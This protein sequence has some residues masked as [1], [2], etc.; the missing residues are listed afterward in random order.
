MLA[1]TLFTV[2]AC[3]H[4][5]RL[6]RTGG[7]W[8]LVEFPALVA[9]LVHP[10]HGPILYDTGYADHFDLATVPFPERLYR[11][12]TPYHLPSDQTLGAQLGRLGLTPADIRLCVIS[13]F[14]GDHVAGLRDLPN[15]TF[16]CLRDD[17]RALAQGS[18]LS[19]LRRGFLP[20]L[21]PSDFE[22]RMQ[23]AD[24][25][26]S[27]T[28]PG[29]LSGLGPAVDLLGDGS[30]A[31]VRLPGHTAGQLGLVFRDAHD[32]RLLLC[33]DAAWHREAIRS[34]DR[35]ARAAA[36]IM[37]DWTAYLATLGR[38]RTVAAAAPDLHIVP[39]HCA[40]SIAAYQALPS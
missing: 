36:L 30:L 2:G 26:S 17:M 11:W 40:D 13:H 24:T 16:V 39:S 6:A 18:R 8:R 38:L 32:R 37:H 10:Q 23:W 34:G 21:L 15:A 3:R 12:T 28:L 29:G 31:G 1:T 4:C 7:R 35:P 22:A 14:H 5:E 25:R 27:L 20:G 19:R 33:A 9:L